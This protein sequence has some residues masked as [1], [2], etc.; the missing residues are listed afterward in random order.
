VL[1]QNFKG[2]DY[3]FLP[4]R[5]RRYFRGAHD[6]LAA[7]SSDG[8][9]VIAVNSGHFIYQTSPD[10]VTAAI[11]EVVEAVRSGDSLAPCNDRFEDLAGACA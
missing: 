5:F 8:I 1:T 4:P 2:N 3:D 7:R 11:I 6:D 10:L 9:H